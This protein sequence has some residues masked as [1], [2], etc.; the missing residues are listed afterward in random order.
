VFGMI[1]RGPIL[2]PQ[3][4]GSVRFIPDAVI[5][6]DARE[7]IEWIGDFANFPGRDRGDIR[8]ADGI[9]CPPFFD[10]HIHIPQHPIRGKFLDGVGALPPGG[11]LL[12]GLSR[13]VFPAEAR[14]ADAK[15]SEQCV[16]EFLD[17]TLA[18]GV[19]GGC[20]YMT[21][22]AR[23]T[24]TALEILPPSWS[25]GLVM[26]NQNCPPDL[27]TDEQNFER[28]VESLAHDFGERFVITDRFAVSVD[29]PLRRR[30]IAL[31]K[32]FSL[33]AQ[34]HLN[35]QLA[36]KHFVENVLYP[37]QAYAGVYDRDGLLEHRPI[38]AHCVHMTPRELNVLAASEGCAVAHC[39]V[40]NSLLGSGI[41][42]LDELVGRGIDYALC[43]DVGASPT[44][45]LLAEMSQFLTVHAGRSNRATPQEALFRCT[46]AAARVMGKDDRFGLLQVGRPM[47]FVEV[48]CDSGSVNAS[49]SADEVIR[50]GLLA[51][52]P[53]EH[54]HED[55]RV[56]LD[57]LSTGRIDA[58]QELEALC[59][60]VAQTASRLDS[61][62]LRVTVD[63]TVIWQRQALRAG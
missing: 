1:V 52:R 23:A 56:Q 60:N 26:M 50:R 48:A 63:G 29:S 9:I 11:R 38:V 39:P 4:D 22:H 21:V 55:L 59:E 7:A 41:M 32:R 8:R 33:R 2:A 62:V 44:T 47:S 58:C 35:E 24:R 6:G 51:Q 57:L 30:G 28:D 18:H 10:D 45:S 43:T 25:V 53:G 5:A 54:G 46:L 61:K 34:T 36:E 37:G 15:H 31:A 42:P 27:R 13:N 17:D 49:L 16:R 3:Y 14:C 19:V 12:A 40:S 20:A